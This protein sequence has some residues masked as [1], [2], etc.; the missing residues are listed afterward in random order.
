MAG[1]LSGV[2]Q[3]SGPPVI[4]YWL[5]RQ[6]VAKSMRANAMVFFCFTTIV[7]GIAY[8]TSGIFTREVM[9][10][11][12]ALVPVYALG[13]F[14]GSRMFGLASERTYRVIAYGSIVLAAVLTLPIF[15]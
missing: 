13:L 5:G 2:A 1:F 14:I 15:G 6:A 11:S 10:Y 9:L 4:L 12:L 3:L 7:A 8:F